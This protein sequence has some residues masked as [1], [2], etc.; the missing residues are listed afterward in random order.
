MGGCQC[1]SPGACSGC[2]DSCGKG[3]LG[4]CGEQCASIC[5]AACKGGCHGNCN[6]VCGTCGG[7]TDTCSGGC[8]SGSSCSADAG[9]TKFNIFKIIIW[10]N[11]RIVNRIEVD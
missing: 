1:Q 2:V 8:K 9:G 7:C 5:G 6:W 11:I 4:S 10:K 3:C